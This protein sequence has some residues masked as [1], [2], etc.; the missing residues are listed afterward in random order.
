MYT[1]ELDIGSWTTPVIGSG[2]I[3]ANPIRSD[4]QIKKEQEKGQL[5]VRKNMTG[6]LMFYGSEM[7][8][9]KSLFDAG[10]IYCGIKVY[11]DSEEAISGSLN[12]FGRYNTQQN[13][14]WLQFTADDRYAKIKASMSMES[15][16]KGIEQ[17]GTTI[18]YQ[19]HTSWNDFLGQD[20]EDGYGPGTHIVPDGYVLVS[21]GST[22]A[23]WDETKTYSHGYLVG[24]AG[25]HLWEGSWD[26]CFCSYGGRNYISRINNNL[27]HTPS[28]ATDFYWWILDEDP[29][30]VYKY[31]QERMDFNE[32][33]ANG[34]ATWDEDN[35]WWYQ[36]NGD[37]DTYDY[38]INAR[39]LFDILEAM[40]AY[41]DPTIEIYF[42]TDGA[43]TG[44]LQYVEDNHP[45]SLD[46]YWKD[47]GDVDGS[48][49]LK[50]SEILDFYKNQFNVDWRFEGDIF[51]FR[52]PSELP[53]T[54]GTDPE[55]DLTNYFGK[56]WTTYEAK[57]EI[58]DR[59]NKEIISF[60]EIR[61][62]DDFNTQEL[63]Y[64]NTFDTSKEYKHNFETDIKHAFVEND[65]Q[66][67]FAVVEDGEL[68]VQAATGLISGE[69][70]YNGYLAASYAFNN[71]YRTGGRPFATAT[72]NTNETEYSL[73]TK[74]QKEYLIKVP[75]FYTDQID[76]ETYLI[77]TTLGNMQVTAIV[78][79]LNGEITEITAMI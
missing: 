7:L 65:K 59:I 35:D 25:N 52:H 58:Q 22:P 38:L 73:T 30:N 6:D 76:Q 42:E 31:G 45:N 16:T 62:A 55:Y 54:L 12:L 44:F 11:W 75:Y 33:G 9:L 3:S 77:K 13:L 23:A 51:V 71:Y 29:G 50:L 78:V 56:D 39:R 2:Y 79:K 48:S 15:S 47:L 27:N 61:A 63:A 20:F 1:I 32:E 66:L 14:A 21:A 43:N 34:T 69:S 64:D 46:I 28:G 60:G 26:D 67:M 68:Y 10:N 18:C 37:S 24:D 57:T 53:S 5:I 36:E 8:V 70:E 74:R 72:L 49:K 41:I 40:L 17:I 19:Q 4:C